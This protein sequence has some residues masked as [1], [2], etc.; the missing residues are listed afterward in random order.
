MFKINK[1]KLE[2]CC[3]EVKAQVLQQQPEVCGIIADT[4][5]LQS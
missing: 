2:K 3:A 5:H 4:L 1:S